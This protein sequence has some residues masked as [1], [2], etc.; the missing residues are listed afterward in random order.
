MEATG[1]NRKPKPR[2]PPFAGRAAA[3]VLLLGLCGGLAAQG[4]AREAGKDGQKPSAPAT[5]TPALLTADEVRYD[6][7]TGRVEAVGDVE[8]SQEG[9]I[10]FADRVAYEPKADRVTATGRVAIL[11]PDGTAV[12]AD[13]VE[14]ENRLKDGIVR[15]IGVLLG[16]GGR[17]AAA[18]GTR[19]GGTVTV[20]DKAVYSTCP[21]CAE[22][23]NPLW[24]IKAER[25]VHDE[26]TKTVVYRN[27]TFEVK[28]VP[29]AFLPYFYNPDPT[30]KRRTGFLAPRIGSDTEL[31]GTLETPF[32]VELAP[33]RDLTLTPM[34]TTKG[35]TLLGIETRDLETFGE[36]RLGGSVAYTESYRRDP[37]DGGNDVRGNV[38]G[39]GRY[40]LA[41]GRR[42]GFDLAY[43]SDNTYLDR[44]GISNEDVLENRAYLER[45]DGLDLL[46]L[47]GLAFQGL[48]E[49]DDQGLIPVVL[50][51]ARARFVSGVDRLGGRFESTSSLLALTRTD[52]LDTR[53]VS[54][55]VGWGVPSLG[56]AGDLRRLS[57]VVR[58]D[59]YNVD[60][61]LS[62]GAGRAESAYVG[63]VVPS[64]TYDWSWPLTAHGGGWQHVIEPTLSAN[65]TGGDANKDDIP[66]EDSLDFELDETNIFEP[67]RFT[68]IDR[69]ESGAKLAYGVRFDSYGSNGWR[70][71]G[72]LAQSARSGPDD[73]F[74]Q[75]SGL[76]G[77]LSDYVGRLDF[78]PGP[79]ID[80]GYRFRLSHDELALRR[81]DLRAEVGPDWLKANFQ[82]LS[83]QEGLPDR[84]LSERRELTAGVRLQLF[85][86]LAVAAQTRRDLERGETVRNTYGFVYTHPCL[87]LVGGLE[88]TYTRQGELGNE[89][90]IGLRISFRSLGNFDG[91]SDF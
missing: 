37:G 81:S 65:W 89:T 34:L 19:K 68:G 9:R 47:E 71:S 44:Y 87:V 23:P 20:L 12:F 16:G 74:A 61:D 79:F 13:E 15:R 45:Y 88:Q 91:S 64:V 60:G 62:L 10:L 43:A 70:V 84:D 90:R 21:V 22:N 57:L 49:D 67:S 38:E 58:A 6:L 36:T 50:P 26:E 80:L 31:G 1:A 40:A 14:V 66:N 25:V 78:Q 55:E 54:T 30:V 52:G 35:G 59:G 7:E 33:N 8:I 29:V 28:G 51:L 56:R 41:E 32:F 82:L 53:R 46:S 69:V 17:F 73:L 85:D 75:G 2:R 77:R 11:D 24:Q 4:S 63:R 5:G 27:A 42:A 48:R 86:N 83:L 39:R 76:A 18:R 3:A 72:A